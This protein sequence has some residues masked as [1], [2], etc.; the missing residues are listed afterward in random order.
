LLENAY[1][2]TSLLVQA[3]QR[4]PEEYEAG[5]E[6]TGGVTQEARGDV[7]E[8][9][10]GAASKLNLHCKSIQLMCK[11]QAPGSVAACAHCIHDSLCPCAR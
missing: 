8:E 3:F 11:C 2:L 5:A 4:I 7:L 9:P 1:I 10:A 6:A